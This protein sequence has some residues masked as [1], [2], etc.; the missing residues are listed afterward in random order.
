MALLVL[1]RKWPRRTSRSESSRSGHAPSNLLVTTRADAKQGRFLFA[2]YHALL[3]FDRS[4]ARIAKIE[5]Q[6]REHWTPFRDWKASSKGESGPM[7]VSKGSQ[8][9][10]NEITKEVT[11]QQR[12]IEREL[13][14]AVVEATPE[15]WKRISLSVHRVDQGLV[16]KI[17]SPEEYSGDIA[18][19]AEVTRSIQELFGL[20]RSAGVVLQ[21]VTYT[22]SVDGDG[23]R[24]EG[25]LER[26]PQDPG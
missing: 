19:T 13:C 8:E 20:Y 5:G 4:V 3:V 7:L 9:M 22:L 12:E 11:D 23:W 6:P 10:R 1:R 2:I 25:Q 18:P 14:N 15:N 26:T 17:G 24:Y 21:R 16:V